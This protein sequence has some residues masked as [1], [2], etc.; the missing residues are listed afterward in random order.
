MIERNALGTTIDADSSIIRTIV[1]KTK[2][3]FIETILHEATHLSSPFK[4]GK[5]DAA[6]EIYGTISDLN[7]MGIDYRK[8]SSI[9][10]NLRAIRM[11]REDLNNLKNLIGE[12]TFNTISRVE[13]I[14]EGMLDVHHLDN[15][16]LN[17]SLDNLIWICPNHHRM[18]HLGIL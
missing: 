18:K 8:L 11:V 10:E 6:L 4:L 15:N 5:I 7:I 9:L 3:K 16:H 12:D 1:F 14:R 13:E 17:N 2:Y